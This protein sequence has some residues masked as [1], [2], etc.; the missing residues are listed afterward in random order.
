MTT[1][2]LRRGATRI[3]IFLLLIAAACSVRAEVTT[4]KFAGTVG[5][6]LDPLNAFNGGIAIGDYFTATVAYDLAHPGGPIVS[7]ANSQ[8]EFYQYAEP[9]W[10]EPL[11]IVVTINGFSFDT[12]ITGTPDNRFHLEVIDWLNNSSPDALN[13]GSSQFEMNVNGAGSYNDIGLAIQLRGVSTT[14]TSTDQPS[15]IDLADWALA[16]A[17]SIFGNAQGVDGFRI[18]GFITGV[19]EPGTLCLLTILGFAGLLVRRRR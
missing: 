5:K 3:G 19:P 9:D 13:M 6:V 16:R 7:D 15:S 11:G 17:L 2:D 1:L 4:A 14:I 8:R 10:H 18:S 12:D